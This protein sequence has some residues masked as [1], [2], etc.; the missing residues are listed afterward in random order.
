MN[1]MQVTVTENR[2]RLELDRLMVVANRLNNAKRN[3][4]FV[5]KALGKHL[6]VEPNMCR[7]MGCLLASLRYGRTAQ[8]GHWVDYVYNP[9][10]FRLTIQESLKQ[11]YR[12]NE[13]VVVMGFAE[14]ATGLGMAVAAA[15][16]DSYYIHT[17]RESIQ[18]SLNFIEFEEEHSHA[19]THQCFP[20]NPERIREADRLIMVDDELTTG[21]SLM[22]MVRQLVRETPIRKF[23]M[24][25]IL[26][27]RHPEQ[28]ARLKE[29]CEEY[30]IEI[31]VQALI[32]GT[33]AT[34]DTTVYQ[35]QE[36]KVLTE[37]M[38]PESVLKLN[39][40]PRITCQTAIGEQAYYRQSG[41]FGI[42]QSEFE[43]MER[44]CHAAARA[45]ADQLEAR[46][47][48]GKFYGQVLVLGHGEDIYYPSRVAAALAEVY[49]GLVDFKSTTRSPIYCKTEERYPIQ[50]SHAFVDQE[51]V[52]YFYY[53][54]DQI[55][56]KY[57]AVILVTEKPVD[58]QLAKRQLTVQM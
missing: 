41:R 5:S 42:S 28:E 30:G 31:E 53:N 4:L 6:E 38:A 51:G 32:K 8:L 44:Y 18:N 16:E 50:Q 39:Q 2:Y 7:V 35:G 10:S 22:N 9:S 45:I 24:L 15:I 55:D 40:I 29:M 33:A 25:T 20:L 36:P 43:E 47:W 11:P 56:E 26:D 13:K 14:T 48:R 23:T 54:K 17:T 37:T 57:D 19:T 1:Q 12:A 3:F 27:W 21:N 49:E 52:T 58:V 34:R 46:Q